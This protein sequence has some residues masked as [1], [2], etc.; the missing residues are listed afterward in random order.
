MTDV[1]SIRP[2]VGML[3]LFPHM[4]YKPWYAIGEL[5][6][7]GIQSYL[8]NRDRLRDDEPGFQLRID[9]TIQKDDGG[10]IV[11]RDNAAGIAAS[12]WGRAFL[13]AEPPSDATGLSQFGIGMKAAACWFAREWS[14][15][16]TALGETTIRSVVFDVP[17]IVASR[18]ESL[19]VHEEPT[20]WSTHFTELTMWNLH[21]VPQTKTLGK[22]RSYLG[23]IYREFLRNGD[24]V[25]TFNGERVSFAEPT[26]LVA[27]RW[28]TLDAEPET[29]RREVDVRLE[30]GRRVRG[31]VALR[32]KGS[33]T[34]SGLALL[35]RRKV[36]TG[37]GDETYRPEEVFG[38]SNSFR[39]QRLFGELE[40]DDFA[41]TYTKDAIV[42]FDEEE[43]FLQELRTLVDSEPLPM[44]RQAENFRSR[45]P[46]QPPVDDVESIVGG[47]DQVLGGNDITTPSPVPPEQ[48]GLPGFEAGVTE[49]TD[50]HES[51]PNV[52]HVMAVMVGG[53]PW[54]VRLRLVSDL[55]VEPWMTSTR[56][57][58]HGKPHVEITVNQAHP[59]MRAFCEVPG[60]ELE[61]V[62]RVAIAL[63]LG[64]ELARN[65]GVTQAGTVTQ[66]VNKL[67]RGAL[68]RKA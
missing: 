60:Q 55:A 35:Y 7:N 24:V 11:V 8:N 4:K 63:G 65:A 59:F 45:V 27:P 16:T 66:Q 47:I 26:V 51:L 2:G 43:E 34:D 57:D 30:S 9:I 54:Q 62:W 36:V 21:R 10:K 13:V 49:G 56:T 12:D 15:R 40:M 41:V 19:V 53:V 17:Q 1:V 64:Q 3:G 14:L 58:E 68:A 31:F 18:D 6:D 29:W 32:E 38:R 23:S 42:W 25:L 20:E 33:T 44:L 39:S 22:M 52:D 46:V 50:G 61:P 48:P 28:S 5:V 37:A 67:L